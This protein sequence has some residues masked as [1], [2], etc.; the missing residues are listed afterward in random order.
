M[1]QPAPPLPGWPIHTTEWLVDEQD[2]DLLGHLNNLATMEYFDRAR[3]Q[4]ITERGHGYDV[5]REC[6]QAPVI[7]AVTVQFRR[8]VH[9]RQRIVI[10]TYTSATSTRTGTVVQVMRTP[11]GTVCV[12]ATYTVGLFDLT[13]RRLIAPTVAWRRACGDP[14]VTAGA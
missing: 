5:I 6:G 9:L 2:I 8:E 14:D 12:V 11:D 13:T 3:W 10:E 1:S 7:V 4:M